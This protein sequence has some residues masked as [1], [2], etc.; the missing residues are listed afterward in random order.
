MLVK[1]GSE[2]SDLSRTM[3][4][5]PRQRRCRLMPTSRSAEWSGEEEERA[6]CK[7]A[8]ATNLIMRGCSGANDSARSGDEPSDCPSLWP[9]RAS[10]APLPPILVPVVRSCHGDGL[11]LLRYHHQRHWGAETRP[12]AARRRTWRPRLRWTGQAFPADTG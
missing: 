4:W 2:R 1:A 11:A 5:M 3:T 8:S 6:R 10:P 9:G 7:L 12:D